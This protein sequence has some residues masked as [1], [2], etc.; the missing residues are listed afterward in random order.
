[1]VDKANV[2]R[3][4]WKPYF[5]VLLTILIQAIEKAHPMCTSTLSC[6]SLGHGRTRRITKKKAYS[7]EHHLSWQVTQDIFEDFVRT[8]EKMSSNNLLSH[9]LYI[10]TDK[11]T[12]NK[13]IQYMEIV[14]IERRR[15]ELW[16][17]RFDIMFTR[18]TEETYGCALP[19]KEQR[20]RRCCRDKWCRLDNSRT[21]L[22]LSRLLNVS[23]VVQ[24]GAYRDTGKT[25]L[26]QKY[27]LQNL[28]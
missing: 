14:T 3:F 4:V 5:A 8:S 15:S 24:F 23:S 20:R 21:S 10:C 12:S 22:W 13:N 7:Q 25:C 1:M 9:D 16:K 6:C 18:W 28:L 17:Q 2:K 11:K 26:I 27:Q 19:A